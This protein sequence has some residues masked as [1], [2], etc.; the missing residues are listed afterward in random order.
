MRAHVSRTVGTTGLAR[1]ETHDWGSKSLE[2][3]PSQSTN[4]TRHKTIQAR[5]QDESNPQESETPRGLVEGFLAGRV[6]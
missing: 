4:K 3:N 2:E 1:K 6:V 5:R